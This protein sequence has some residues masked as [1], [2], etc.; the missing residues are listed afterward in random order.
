MPGFESL[1]ART[2]TLFLNVKYK[3]GPLPRRIRTGDKF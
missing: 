3:N 2:K 1:E